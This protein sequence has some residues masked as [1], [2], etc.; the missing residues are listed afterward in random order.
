MTVAAGGFEAQAYPVSVDVDPDLGDR[1]R[2]TVAF[3]IILAIPH[4]LLVGSPGFAFAFGAGW[5]GRDNGGWPA[6]GGGGVLGAVAAV[7]AFIAWFAILFASQHP[8]G[9]WDMGSF[10]M[11]WRARA[12]AYITLLRD[13]YPPFGDGDYASSLSVSYP[14]ESQRN[15][16]S[17]GLRIFYVIPHAI[18]LFFLWIAWSIVT[19]IAWFAILFTGR[20]PA[21]LADF[22]VGVMRWSL[23]VEAYVLLV[24]DE[25]PPFSLQP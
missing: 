16:L 21:G 3:R 25:Y 4:L 19:L 2:L 15:K 10:Y 7:C 14:D 12:L 13:E 24:R 20:Y 22:A 23:R 9:L 18:I 11:R 17:V 6:I 1:N 5:W 8:K